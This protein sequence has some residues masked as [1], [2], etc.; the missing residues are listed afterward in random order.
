MSSNTNENSW[1]AANLSNTKCSCKNNVCLRSSDSTYFVDLPQLIISNDLFF[2]TATL[3]NERE[4]GDL[5]VCLG[6]AVEKSAKQELSKMVN[7]K[8]ST[9]KANITVMWPKYFIVGSNTNFNTRIV[10]D[11]GVVLNG[12]FYNVSNTNSSSINVKNFFLLEKKDEAVVKDLV[13]LSSTY[14]S[15]DNLIFNHIVNN[16]NSMTS[17]KIYCTR[18]DLTE[19]ILD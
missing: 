12:Y 19:L 1:L 10:K 16:L 13:N 9:I 4:R 15:P 6:L 7:C 18:L 5:L 17:A 2:S 8:T 14:F 11:N 3:E